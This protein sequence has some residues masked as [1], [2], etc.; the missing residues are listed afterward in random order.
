M[1]EVQNIIDIEKVIRNSDSK[2]VR[3]L[4][5]FIVRMIRRIIRQDEL[6]ATLNKNR[7]KTGI[8]FINDV[9]KD[10]NISIIVKG[11]ENVP[12][13][14]RF[15][16]AAN[17]PLGG[18][19]ALTFLSTIHSFF[20]DVISPSNQLFN[21]IPNLR[22]VILGVNVFGVNTKETVTKF[23]QLFES[24]T[25]IMIFPAGIVSRRKK[26]V[27]SDLQW[28]KTFITKSI[29]FRR[30]I[31]PV[32]ISGRNSNLFYF[33]SNLRKFLGIKM[34]VEIILLPREM[35][36]QRNSSV[37]LT[38]GKPISYKTLASGFNNSEGAQKIKSLVY[39]LPE[40]NSDN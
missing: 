17:H 33:L 2:F 9:L 8:P 36:R 11:G 21:Y 26:G 35:M 23:N 7:S 31:I 19:D 38:I 18:I 13:S 39:T 16:F 32:H 30:D 28:Q 15:V 34:S 24:D 10:W 5:D 37:T 29:Q 40:K 12:S 14:G 6:N 25:Q 1:D 20:P 3:S 27:I 22:T 4:P